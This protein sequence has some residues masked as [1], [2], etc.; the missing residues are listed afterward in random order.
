[1]MFV[2]PLTVIWP[3]YQ[4]AVVS[5]KCSCALASDYHRSTT[6][7]ARSYCWVGFLH[8]CFLVSTIPRFTHSSWRRGTREN[9]IFLAN[10]FAHPSLPWRPSTPCRLRWYA[11]RLSPH[12]MQ[13]TL[14]AILRISRVLAFLVILILLLSFKKENALLHTHSKFTHQHH[15]RMEQSKQYRNP[16]ITSITV[17]FRQ[18]AIN[19]C[20][21][22]M[23]STTYVVTKTNDEEVRIPPGYY[24]IG[25]IIAILNTITDTVFSISTKALSYSCI[26]IQ[27]SHSIHFTNAPDIPEILGMEKWTVIL[28]ASFNQSYVFDI[29]RNRH[30]IYMYSSLVRSSDLKIA[31]QNNN[32]L[33][34]MI[35]NNPT[36][37]SSRSVENICIP[38]ITRFDRLMCVLNNL[39]DFKHRIFRHSNAKNNE[40]S[41]ET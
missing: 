5:R 12:G 9:W 11:I 8:T 17:L 23:D 41:Q 20:T 35:I 22:N 31:S 10:V 7:E 21:N 29:T 32:L 13:T 14:D 30:V 36:A 2:G 34:T 38:K 27:S 18:N 16:T 28:P 4:N 19:S 37:H 3:S 1:M 33:T 39:S 40:I 25:E 6:R 15:V 26:W 24:T